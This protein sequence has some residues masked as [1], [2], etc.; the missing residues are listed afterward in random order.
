MASLCDKLLLRLP[1]LRTARR[2]AAEFPQQ[3]R[4]KA[5]TGALCSAQSKA[6]DLLEKALQGMLQSSPS[7]H[8]QLAQVLL[9]TCLR[10]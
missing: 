5:T 8:A 3:S 10:L 9:S 4:A 6:A 2:H 7:S 1:V